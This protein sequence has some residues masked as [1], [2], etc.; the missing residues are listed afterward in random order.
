MSEVSEKI[1][2]LAVSIFPYVYKM[3]RRQIWKS[4]KI[5]A[6]YKQ[7]YDH[8]FLLFSYSSAGDDKD[9]DNAA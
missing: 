8:T 2:K 4:Q 7:S 9:D 6:M 3:S 5:L 1:S